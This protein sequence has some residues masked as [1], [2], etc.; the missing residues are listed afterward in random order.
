MFRFCEWKSDNTTLRG[1]VYKSESAPGP[2]IIYCHG[3]G[4]HRIGPHYLFAKLAR[5]LVSEGI[6][7]L[8]FDFAGC[9]ESEGAF[10]DMTLASM[11]QDLLATIRM[12]R[13]Q[14]APSKII[15]LGYSLGSAVALR[16]LTSFVPD[17]VILLAP[18]TETTVHAR[19]HEYVLHNGCNKQ[20]YYELG[21]FEMKSV[22]LK[23]LKRTDALSGFENGFTKPLLVIQGD[24]DAT[25]SM[26]ETQRFVAHVKKL[27][28]PLQYHVI[29]GADHT[30][31]QVTSRKCILHT[32]SRWVKEY[33]L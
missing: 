15:I 3:F 18:V 31:S 8:T 16:S 28:V 7:S 9:G 24:T 22:F 30:F 4:S 10:H 17:G 1:S 33:V 26:E 19:N 27:P 6:S 25:I 20:G 14:Y 29:A 21:P 5:G 32:V 2:W 23:E 13:Q 12:V 11:C